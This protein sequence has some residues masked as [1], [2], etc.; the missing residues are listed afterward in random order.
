MGGATV[1]AQVLEEQN[2]IAG[3]EELVEEIERQV[4]AQAGR[5]CVAAAVHQRWKLGIGGPC[6]LVI[7]SGHGLSLEH[8]NSGGSIHVR[9]KLHGILYSEGG[10]F[11]E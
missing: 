7:R 1:A 3:L 6:E 8:G 5:K 10:I 2:R 9:F 11:L 4:H